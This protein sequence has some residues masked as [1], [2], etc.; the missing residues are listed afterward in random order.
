MADDTVVIFTADHGD[1]LGERG[2]WYKMCFFEH[3]CRIP[4]IVRRPG[5][6][7][8]V[9]AGRVNQSHVSL[10][11]I[12][13][14]LLD[15][16]GIEPPDDMDGAS[17]LPLLDDATDVERTVLGEYLGEGAAAPIFMIRRGPWKFVWSQPD[18]A[19]L[20]DLDVD[21][22]ELVDLVGDPDHTDTLAD[23]TAEML[24]RWDPD[25]IDAAVRSS[26]RA[27]ALVDS[28]LR[29]GRFAAWDYQP[30]TDA[31]NQYMRNHL[32]L[33]EVEAGRRA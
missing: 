8:D 23:F 19:Q 30:T 15:I 4:L 18:G 26:Q 29:R 11:D 27:R 24:R 31:T 25:A 32:D 28:A 9:A 21:P 2:L 20:F 16:A 3:A 1:M 12:A 5:L 6:V 13:P 10:L 22:H 7:D 14:T 33:N 17:V